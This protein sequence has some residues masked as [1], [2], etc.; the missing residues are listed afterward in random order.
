MSLKMSGECIWITGPG[1]LST[2]LKCLPDT[3]GIGISS[4]QIHQKDLTLHRS[5]IMKQ[6]FL[7]VISA[8]NSK[9]IIVTD[10]ILQRNGKNIPACRSFLPAGPQTNFCLLILLKILIMLFRLV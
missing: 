5:V 3:I 7:S 6:L 10:A 4:G 8:L 9:A 1:H 2:L